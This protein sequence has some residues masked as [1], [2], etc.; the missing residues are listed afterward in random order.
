MAQTW[1]PTK[2]KAA[3]LSLVDSLGRPA[4]RG[5]R[6]IRGAFRG[7]AG[8]DSNPAG[9]TDPRSILV[10]ELWQIGDVVLVTRFLRALRKCFPNARISLLGKSH[11]SELLAESGLV[12]EVIVAELPW[13][14]P[15][16]KYSP[17]LYDRQFLASLIRGLRARRFDVSFDARMDIRS[18][19]L[20][21]LIAPQRRIGFRHGGGDWLLTDAVPLDPRKNH[22]VDDWLALLPVAGC[23]LP[24]ERDCLLRTTEEE[25]ERA[26]LTLAALLPRD[27]R[28]VAI[29]PGG[30]HAGKRWPLDSF[31]LLANEL[32]IRGFNVIALVDPS[33]YGAEL[34]SVHGVVTFSPGIREM[35]AILER[36]DVLVCNDS[37]PM[38][39]AAALGVPTVAI[40]ERGEPRWFGPVG[41][42][43]IVIAGEL[44]GVAVSAAPYSAPPK[45]PVPVARVLEATI[46]QLERTGA[47]NTPS[48]AVPGIIFDPPQQDFP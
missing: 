1:P 31:M 19:V 26:R 3:L 5:L 13:T 16:N 33:G 20:V 32:G 38:H 43:H 36:C 12:D 30:S 15:A 2:W 17:R 27:G 14:R 46:A 37:G 48:S 21:A 39:V 4:A 18:N 11:A 41:E 45:N 10:I 40:F 47:Q 22:K 44:A 24:A 23:N 29:H 25:R 42:G 9:R 6:F 28:T 34:G 8:D 35:M 7:V